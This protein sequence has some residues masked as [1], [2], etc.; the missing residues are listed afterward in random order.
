MLYFILITM[1]LLAGLLAVVPLVRSSRRNTPAATTVS[2]VKDQLKEIDQDVAEGRIGPDAEEATRLEVKRRLLD[3]ADAET[4]GPVRTMTKPAPLA[5][6]TFVA[7]LAIS[8]ALYGWLGAPEFTA[9]QARFEE[10]Q[11]AQA[12]YFVELRRGIE[13]LEAKIG[14]GEGSGRDWIAIGRAY[15][16]LGDFQSA[17]RSFEA[18]LAIDPE[19]AVLSLAAGESMVLAGD[20]VVS[21]EAVALFEDTLTR[22]PELLGAAFYIALAQYQAGD[23]ASAYDSWLAIAAKSSAGDPWMELIAFYLKNTAEELG[24]PAP[25]LPAMNDPATTAAILEMV[26]Q[27]SDRL[28]REGGN[29]EEW[30]ML[31]RSYSVLNR[32]DLAVDAYSEAILQE[33]GLLAAHIGIAEAMAASDGTEP[34][35]ERVLSAFEAVL[36]I[37]PADPRALYMTAIGYAKRGDTIGA[38]RNFAALL[39]QLTPETVEYQDVRGR[40][41]ALDE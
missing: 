14:R 1:A 7:T 20:G 23:L 6:T 17:Q 9:L 8:A 3:A 30:V 15:T 25:E 28:E 18:A 39:Q 11:A 26:E 38:S 33:P 10:D 29:A 5:V 37:A 22:D 35:T 13:L 27:L 31:G 2:V 24:I 4:V 34:I 16:E 36:V 19:N 12:S 40:L 41:R 32:F 21:P